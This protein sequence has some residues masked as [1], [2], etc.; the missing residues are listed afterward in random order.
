MAIPVIMDRVGSPEPEGECLVVVMANL[1]ARLIHQGIAFCERIL[2]PH[3]ILGEAHA[4]ER[5]FQKRRA[6][7]HR[8]DVIP[9]A[10]LCL[11]SS[12]QIH[13]LFWITKMNNARLGF[14]AGAKPF[15]GVLVHV[16][17]DKLKATYPGDARIA[18]MLHHSLDPLGVR[19]YGILH[20]HRHELAFGQP[21]AEISGLPVVEFG[22]RDL[23]ESNGELRNYVASSIGGTGINDDNLQATVEDLGQDPAQTGSNCGLTI[24]SGDHNREPHGLGGLLLHFYQNFK[25][26]IVLP[27]L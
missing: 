10:K 12:R 17:R 15:H 21:N 27:S 18:E 22:R 23:V 25:P 5:G 9:A 16:V 14:R 24:L 13:E 11:R 4:L 20:S 1:S 19:W 2:G 6:P 3:H 8:R 26:V 7:I